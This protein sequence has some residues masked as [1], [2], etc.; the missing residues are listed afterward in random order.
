MKRYERIVWT[1]LILSSFHGALLA[2]DIERAREEERARNLAARAVPNE[3]LTRAQLSAGAWWKN[4]AIAQALKLTDDQKAKIEKAFEDHWRSI[5]SDT[6]VL[7]REEA[8]LA[9]LLEAERVD[10]GAVT[11]QTARVIQARGEVE[12]STAM[13]TIEMREQLTRTQ[14]IQLQSE[15]RRV[16]ER[17]LA[18]PGA[19]GERGAAPPQG[20]IIRNKTFFFELWDAQRP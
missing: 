18:V 6:E 13:M 10:R 12:R 14:W 2:Q 11:S 9:R 16:R 19:G 15:Q 7:E 4:E 8:Q 17:A 1:V 3:R 20:G 5:V